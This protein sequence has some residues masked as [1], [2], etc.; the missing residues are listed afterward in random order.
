LR[1]KRAL[2]EDDV[3]LARQLLS[4]YEQLR[5]GPA[6]AEATHADL[7]ALRRAIRAFRPRPNPL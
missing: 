3:R 6:S 7:R 2:V 1:T 5:Y 4:R